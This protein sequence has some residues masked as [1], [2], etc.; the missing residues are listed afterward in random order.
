MSKVR[1]NKF[2]AEAGITSRRKADALIEAGDVMINGKRVFE[3]GVQVDPETDKV[4][5]KGKP[6]Q[7]ED[8]KV[9][10]MFFKPK[11]VLTSME[12]PEGRPTVG[13]FFK[14]LPYRVF[15]I[16][17][18]DWDSEG[19]LLLTNDGDYGNRVMHP[20]EEIPKTYHVKLNGQPTDAHVEKLLR[21]VSIVGGKVAAREVS[22]LRKGN[23]TDKSWYRIVITEGKNRQIRRMFEKLG[24]DVEKLHR[25]AIGELELRGIER[26]EYMMLSPKQAERVFFTKRSEPTRKTSAKRF[27]AEPEHK[28][29]ARSENEFS[30]KKPFTKSK[31]GSKGGAKR[32]YRGRDEFRS[33]PKGK[34][35]ARSEAR[36]ETNSG[37][38][39]G[40]PAGRGSQRER[41][42]R[43]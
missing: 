26:G 11:N 17:R 25:V 27:E 30:A 32:D 36:N 7:A 34:E 43:R 33:G 16:G 9:Y 3:L 21:G 8:Q 39:Q 14:D 38:S 41:P 15:P 10:I 1:L 22:R 42:V 24:Y 4:S 23:L 19:L 28:P 31:S 18:L 35:G 6:I 40:R 20:R 37:K 12:D 5:V 2:I 13:D 29:R